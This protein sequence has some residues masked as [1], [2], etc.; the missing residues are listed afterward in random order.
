[1]ATIDWTTK[2][3]LKLA[4]EIRYSGG[5]AYMSRECPV[6]R[7]DTLGLPTKRRP[8]DSVVHVAVDVISSEI[9]ADTVARLPALDIFTNGDDLTSHVR[10]RDKVIWISSVERSVPLIGQ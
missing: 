4:L 5:G 7:Q 9:G 3:V 2:G 6:F 10:A 1:M 8:L